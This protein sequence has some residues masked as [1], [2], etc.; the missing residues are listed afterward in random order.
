MVKIPSDAKCVFNG[1]L[2]DVYHWEQKL[3]DGSYR[4]FE[5]VKRI[6]SVQIISINNNNNKIVLLKE[7]QPHVGSFIS[8]PGGMVERGDSEIDTVHKELREE[9]GMKS[10]DVIFWKKTSL[11][12]KI[13]WTSNFFIAKNCIKCSETQLEAGEKIE[14]YEV[15]FE[16]FLEETQ[17]EE[18]RNKELSNMIF[19]I[20][21]TKGELEKFRKMLFE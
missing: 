16:E 5:A 17:K 19:R 10:D 12:S 8:I 14:A 2:F 4:T 6:P 11:G 9:L 7:E 13:E 3:F 15:S 18:F 21:H 1:I 20:I